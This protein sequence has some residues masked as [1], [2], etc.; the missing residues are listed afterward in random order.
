MG[1]KEALG[2]GMELSSFFLLSYLVSDPI[3]DKMSWD[4]NLTLSGL[5]ALSLIAWTFHAFVF[6]QRRD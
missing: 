6:F 3:A 4:S 1:M 2:L 5:L